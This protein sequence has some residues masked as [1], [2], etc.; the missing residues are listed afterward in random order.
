MLVEQAPEAVDDPVERVV[1]ATP[2]WPSTSRRRQPPVGG[3]RLVLGQAL[4]AQPAAVDRVVGVALHGHGPPVAHAE[5]HAA[6]DRAVPARRAHPAVDGAAGADRPPAGLVDV[7]VPVPAVVDA[8]D[9]AQPGARGRVT[10]WFPAVPRQN[11]PGMLSGT[12]ATKNSHRP[13]SS[14]PASR[15]NAAA[16]HPA[17]ASGDPGDPGGAAQ[18]RPGPEPAQLEAHRAPP[19]LPGRRARRHQFKAV[20]A[21]ATAPPAAASASVPGEHRPDGGGR[22]EEAHDRQWRVP[23]RPARHDV[24]AGGGVHPGR[25]ESD[26]RPRRDRGGSTAAAATAAYA[27]RNSD[28]AAQPRAAEVAQ[29]L[30]RHRRA[31][32]VEQARR[33]ARRR[34]GDAASARSGVEP[35]VALTPTAIWLTSVSHTSG[36]CGCSGRR[37]Q[38]L[39]ANG[40]DRDV[41]G[42]HDPRRRQRERRR[43]AAAARRRPRGR[44]ATPRR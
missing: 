24:Q 27:E 16:G 13:I 38:S 21:S 25:A 18:H 8:E 37:F 15:T 17:T 7:R 28:L 39:A 5:Q 29:R 19:R 11:A 2:A 34:R 31:A 44:P 23:R 22:G 30:P 32:E 33:R 3:D 41:V 40:V 12:T 43:S 1:P 36:Q 9:G 42:Q 6:A 14:A 4:R 26:G 10:G 35:A 20:A